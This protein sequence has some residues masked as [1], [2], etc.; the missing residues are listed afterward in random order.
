MRAAG[1]RYD[2][3]LRHRRDGLRSRPPDRPQGADPRAR[4][5]GYRRQAEAGWAFGRPD[6]AGAGSACQT[7][8]TA[9]REE[10]GWACQTP[11]SGG[12][13]Q[14]RA[15]WAVAPVR[16][17]VHR[18]PDQGPQGRARPTAGARSAQAGESA[19]LGVE[20]E[21]RAGW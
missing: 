18:H 3:P 15:G 21:V 13:R 2:Q 1:S 11:T 4:R 6:R 20:R 14:A 9:V 5:N 17:V 10:V 12:E 7:L 8:T 19:V 16:P